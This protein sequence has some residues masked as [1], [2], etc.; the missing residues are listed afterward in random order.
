MH[1]TDEQLM[2]RVDGPLDAQAEA[3]LAA[4]AHC[5]AAVEE[6]SAIWRLLPAE[7]VE[8]S[9]SFDARMRARLDALDA[10][11]WSSWAWAAPSLAAA[12]GVA[13]VVA[14]APP[15]SK[16]PPPGELEM[17]AELELY[18]DLEAAELVDVYADLD[19]IE[20]LDGSEG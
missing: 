16:A 4:C 15:V 3:H 7:A 10:R 9:P 2:K 1:L 13:V 17:L 11:S 20:T 14:A 5:R 12:M 6:T 18:D 19:V 8:P